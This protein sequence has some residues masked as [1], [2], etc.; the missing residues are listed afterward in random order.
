M[1]AFL[2]TFQITGWLIFAFAIPA[3][4]S[5]F[6]FVM[7][8][9]SP[10]GIAAPVL[11]ASFGWLLTRLDFKEKSWKQTLAWLG[12]AWGLVGALIVYLIACRTGSAVLLFSGIIP[13]LAVALAGLFV[14]AYHRS[15]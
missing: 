8:L 12:F 6:F 14:I 4:I 1:Q 2:V 11:V 10:W 15:E 5:G 7:A 13:S 3:L 9:S